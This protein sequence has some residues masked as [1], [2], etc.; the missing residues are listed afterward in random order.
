MTAPDRDA[1]FAL[2]EALDALRVADLPAN[3]ERLV[4]RLAERQEL[5]DRLQAFDMGALP[6]AVRLQVRDRLQTI[7]Q[8]T[9]VGL[10]RVGQ[11]Y[12]QARKK[13]GSL[14][15]A[16]GAARGYRPEIRRS[17]AFNRKA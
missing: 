14:V 11:T 6:A 3:D 2:L 12:E 8:D 4:A 13:Q 9:A 15:T 7:N 5:L 16:R 10:E 1:V 17:P